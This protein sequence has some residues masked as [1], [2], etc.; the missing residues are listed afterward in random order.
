[1]PSCTSVCR[2][3]STGSRR[4]TLSNL[5]LCEH[6]EN[7]SQETLCC[8]STYVCPSSRNTA[9]PLVRQL[10]EGDDREREL[11]RYLVD[12]KLSGLE[13]VVNNARVSD[14][15]WVTE[16]AEDEEPRRAAS[17]PHIRP[18]LGSR[19]PCENREPSSSALS[20]CKLKRSPRTRLQRR[21][22]SSPGSA[23]KSPRRFPTRLRGHRRIHEPH[24]IVT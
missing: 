10:V 13:E 5:D 8:I 22:C 9:G 12:D 20:R 19:Q 7:A 21:A 2:T 24:H 3:S 14:A 6:A 16:N 11:M 23:R 1:M 17:V 4:R 15:R 18:Y